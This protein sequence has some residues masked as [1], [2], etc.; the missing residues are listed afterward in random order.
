MSSSEPLSQKASVISLF[1]VVADI[2]EKGLNFTAPVM[3]P[4]TGAL[5]SKDKALVSSTP[6][7][8]IARSGFEYPSLITSSASAYGII[9]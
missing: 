3:K 4:S 2:N 8:L 1:I 6:I 5:P 7:L 9:P